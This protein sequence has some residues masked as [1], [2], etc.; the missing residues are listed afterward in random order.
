M[1]R[2]VELLRYPS[3]GEWDNCPGRSVGV[4]REGREVGRPRWS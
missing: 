1:L 4:G 3:A 2:A